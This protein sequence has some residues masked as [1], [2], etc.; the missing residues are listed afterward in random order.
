METEITG[1][2]RAF[3]PAV[4]IAGSGSINYERVKRRSNQ[5]VTEQALSNGA[6]TPEDLASNIIDYAKH[7]AAVTR[8]QRR[9]QP[10]EQR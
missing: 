4:S 5:P 8:G 6:P 2:L 7:G 1:T 10:L 9:S 3:C